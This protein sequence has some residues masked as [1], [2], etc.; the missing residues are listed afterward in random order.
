MDDYERVLADRAPAFADKRL[1]PYALEWDAT[2]HFPTDVLREA[3][4][5]GMAAI[6]CRD[7]VGGS[8]LHRLDGVRI[9]ELLAIADPT[10]AAFLSIHNMCA[11]MIDTFGSDEQ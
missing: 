9:F 10:T 5:L 7:D 1:A 2:K 11:W 6:Y 4:E 3:A 8:G